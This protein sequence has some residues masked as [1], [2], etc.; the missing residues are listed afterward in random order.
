MSTV[1]QN[2]RGVIQKLLLDIENKKGKKS[3]A[4]ESSKSHGN[5]NCLRH[6]S[7]KYEVKNRAPWLGALRVV[8]TI[9]EEPELI[10][11]DESFNAEQHKVYRSLSN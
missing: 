9:K 11:V 6:Q 2:K 8:D 1:T 5:K 3:P 10:E 4:K 7:Q